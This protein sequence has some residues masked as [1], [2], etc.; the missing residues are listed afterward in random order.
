MS[1]VGFLLSTSSLE[2]DSYY[3]EQVLKVVRSLSV[4]GAVRYIGQPKMVVYKGLFL[5]EKQIFSLLCGL[6]HCRL[7]GIEKVKKYWWCDTLLFCNPV[8]FFFLLGWVGMRTPPPRKS[9]HLMFEILVTLT[10]QSDDT[11]CNLLH[12]SFSIISI[13][14]FATSIICTY[15][16]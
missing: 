9:W 10:D 5:R 4:F 14:T 12:T 15:C 11:N 1:P 6:E 16:C 13:V 2:S 7:A 8:D 3:I